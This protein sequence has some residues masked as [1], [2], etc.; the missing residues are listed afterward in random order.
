MGY[1]IWPQG[2]L[3]VSSRIPPDCF[4]P[5]RNP[6]VREQSEIEPVLACISLE[7][8]VV[9]EMENRKHNGETAVHNQE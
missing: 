5:G 9:E 1:F 7:T 4:A 2:I 8:D 3:L 6:E